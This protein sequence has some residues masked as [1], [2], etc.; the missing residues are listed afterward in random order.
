[1]IQNWHQ[2][3]GTKSLKNQFFEWTVD[4]SV[5]CHPMDLNGKL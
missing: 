1:M 3:S 2:I 5:Y 4:K